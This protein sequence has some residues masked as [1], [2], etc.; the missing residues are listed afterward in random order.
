[1]KSKSRK[2]ALHRETL[3]PLELQ[4]AR[5]AQGAGGDV[6]QIDPTADF[7]CTIPSGPFLC[8]WP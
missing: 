6:Q 3:K 8:Q 7:G 2:L 1:M 4:A 5:R